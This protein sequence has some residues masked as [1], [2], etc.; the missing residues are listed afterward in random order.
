L[1]IVEDQ[2]GNPTYAHDIAKAIVAIL[3]RLNSE[4]HL[5]GTYNFV[6]KVNCSWA[7]FAEDIFKE[8]VKQGVL[9][10]KPK[11]NKISTSEFPTL[12]KRPMHS[13]L[14]FS[15]FKSTFGINQ[16]NYADSICSTLESYKELKYKK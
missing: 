9:K 7:D 14:D 10:Y 3:K 11:I 1:S 6:G 16:S 2:V 15:K 12:A 13:K 5:I 4:E 8:A